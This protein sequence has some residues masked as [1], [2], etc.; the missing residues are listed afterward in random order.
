[1]AADFTKGGPGS[2]Q[3]GT[4]G[5]RTYCDGDRFLIPLMLVESPAKTR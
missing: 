2:L 1:M 4:R 5:V 3:E